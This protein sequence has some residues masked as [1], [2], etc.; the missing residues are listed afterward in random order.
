M[1]RTWDVTT[2]TTPHSSPYVLNASNVPIKH[3]GAADASVLGTREISLSNPQSWSAPREGA[4]IP[5]GYY[6]CRR[7]GIDE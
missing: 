7:L 4:A 2:G 1:K 3:A 6:E 5:T